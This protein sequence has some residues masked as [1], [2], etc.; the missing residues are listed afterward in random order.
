[1][2][3]KPCFNL[4]RTIKKKKI[5]EEKK[6]KGSGHISVCQANHSILFVELLSF[7]YQKTYYVS[8]ML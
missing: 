6:G 1:M 4:Y 8:F 5:F 3:H 2:N 7:Q